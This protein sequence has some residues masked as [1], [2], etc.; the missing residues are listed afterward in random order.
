MP[1]QESRAGR[2]KRGRDL[3][4]SEFIDDFSKS[5]AKV[6]KQYAKRY[7]LP[8]EVI[9]EEQA[10]SIVISLVGAVID[11]RPR[12]EVEKLLETKLMELGL[13]ELAD[14][15]SNLSKDRYGD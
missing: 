2:L 8:E 14:L 11:E 4:N 6:S 13:V 1:K 3:F 12:E 7:D 9:T 5:L 10:K 15:E